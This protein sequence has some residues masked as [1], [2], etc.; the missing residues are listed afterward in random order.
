MNTRKSDIRSERSNAGSE[1]RSARKQDEARRNK[2]SPI[3]RAQ[4]T[5]SG[6]VY[7]ISNVGSFGERIFKVGMT[8]RLEPMD[9]V[10][11]LG[12]ASV[13]FPFD[14]HAMLYSDNAPELETALHRLVQDRQVN[15]MNVRKE[16]YRDVE[17]DEIEAFVKSRGLR[18]QFIKIPEAKEY[19]ETLALRQQ[20]AATAHA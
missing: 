2:K 15:L 19:R 20:R 4:L 9:R 12:D 6:F 3:A 7:V 13:P 17:L 8:R 1:S 11:E 14:L 10:D 18:A 16:F 5:K